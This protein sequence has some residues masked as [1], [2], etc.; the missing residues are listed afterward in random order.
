M[1]YTEKHCIE[2][3]FLLGS[4]ESMTQ[5][6]PYSATSTTED[7]WHGAQAE[8]DPKDRRK[9]EAIVKDAG[10]FWLAL[11][12]CILCSALGCVLIPIWYSVRLLQWNAMNRKYPALG[13]IDA[14]PGTL[15]AKFRRVPWK[16]VVGIAVGAVVLLFY[17]GI[18][19]LVM[20][21]PA[22]TQTLP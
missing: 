8:I 21:A 5:E 22:P 16:L 10:Q 7:N 19:V 11:L 18:L 15:S 20:V 12:M 1:H 3:A 9:I 13:A 4:D 14:A 2:A 17:V 6:N